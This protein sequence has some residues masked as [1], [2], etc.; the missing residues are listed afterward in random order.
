MFCLDICRNSCYF[1]SPEIA[2]CL[3]Q[4]V[5]MYECFVIDCRKCQLVM[6]LQLKNLNI[7]NVHATT[8]WLRMF[9]YLFV[10]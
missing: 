3:F 1:V 8:Y 5:Y 9:V 10:S 6:L 7:L 4:H 2:I